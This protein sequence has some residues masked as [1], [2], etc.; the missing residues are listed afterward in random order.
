MPDKHAAIALSYNGGPISVQKW[1]IDQMSNT[2]QDAVSWVKRTSDIHGSAKI[3][4]YLAQIKNGLPSNTWQQVL[5][6]D[7][8]KGCDIA[9]YAGRPRSY[10]GGY[11]WYTLWSQNHNLCYA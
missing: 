6:L 8:S 1:T 7:K 2:I 10:I 11:D 9:T 5:Q 4:I 3:A